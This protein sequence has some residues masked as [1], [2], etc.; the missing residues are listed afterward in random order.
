MS[1]L[2]YCSFIGRLGQDPEMKYLPSTGDGVCKFSI[3]TSETWKD[4]QTGTKKERTTWVNIE[5]WGKLAEICNEYL[6]KGKQVFV[7]GR[8]VNEEWVKDGVKRYF[9]KIKIDQMQMLGGRDDGEPR[10]E[11]EPS[12]RPAPAA[13]SSTSGGGGFEDDDIP[14]EAYAARRRW[15]HS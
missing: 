14:F 12:S 8:M 10:Q 3:A 15:Y 11:R 7:S 13:E 5:A 1:D 2:N 6:R 4:K 9:T